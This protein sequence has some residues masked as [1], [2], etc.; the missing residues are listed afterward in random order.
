MKVDAPYVIGVIRHEEK[1]LLQED[2]YV[3]LTEAP[4][5]KEAAHVLLDTP[6]GTWMTPESGPAEAMAALE[7]RLAALQLWLEDSV[8]DQRLLQFIQA[9]YDALNIAS[10]LMSLFS[11][12]EDPGEL[13]RLGSIA[14]T[15]LRSII[16]NDVDWEH[17]P[18]HWEDFLHQEKERHSRKEGNTGMAGLLRRVRVKEA[19]IMRDTARTL[20][21]RLVAEQASD[22]LWLD[23]FLREKKLLSAE[24][25]MQ[26]K[27]SE[28]IKDAESDPDYGALEK[29]LHDFGYR[30]L[31][32][33]ALRSVREAEGSM[34]YEQGW[35]ERLIR[36]LRPFTGDPVG[37]D[38]I[39]AFWLAVEMEAKTVRLLL[40]A[41]AQRMPLQ[42]VKKMQRPLYLAVSD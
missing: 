3:R 34:A 41:K 4:T 30:G 38:A 24:T 36:E 15:V 32:E 31:D 21:S 40:S 28:A 17:I 6:Y 7:E 18:E 10:A 22:R 27:L 5:V 11:G 16:W 35:D 23:L 19:E 1:G 33:E 29:T 25:P 8:D 42:E 20:L 37:S 2:E 12:D 39:L 26:H 14:P 13:S 9:R